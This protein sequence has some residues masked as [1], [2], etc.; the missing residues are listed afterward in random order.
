MNENQGSE[1]TLSFQL[2]L[3]EM[4]GAESAPAERL[5]AHEAKR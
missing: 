5:V 4:R 1:S 3:L 2:A